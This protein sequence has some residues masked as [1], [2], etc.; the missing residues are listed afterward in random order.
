[1]MHVLLLCILAPA[2]ADV[3]GSMAAATYGALYS[4]LAP[5]HLPAAPSARAQRGF[6]LLAAGRFDAAYV[7]F[8]RALEADPGDGAA[9]AG[10]AAARA[11]Y[12]ADPQGLTPLE[13]VHT[14]STA[15]FPAPLVRSVTHTVTEKAMARVRTP[16]L[17]AEVYAVV[18][19]LFRAAARRRAIGSIGA[20]VRARS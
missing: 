13:L 4:P 5:A 2:L 7:D 18:L 1:M 12:A 11:W 6:G 10:L 14:G 3:V 16:S 19:P 8:H 20:R 9:A 15:G 17:T